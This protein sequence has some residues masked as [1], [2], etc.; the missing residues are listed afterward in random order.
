MEEKTNRKNLL[1]FLSDI[2]IFQ[3]CETLLPDVNYRVIQFL[4][5]Y[6]LRGVLEMLLFSLA[7]LYEANASCQLNSRR[8][9][10]LKINCCISWK[11]KSESR[12]STNLPTSSHFVGRL[13]L[14]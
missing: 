6:P 2:E 1:Q 14:H 8:E 12:F 3:C 4:S 11:D 13:F 7:L 9:I 10:I 5:K